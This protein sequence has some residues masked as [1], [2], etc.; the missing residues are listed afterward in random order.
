MSR[1]ISFLGLFFPPPPVRHC[2]G[3]LGERNFLEFKG[4]DSDKSGLMG[5][6]GGELVLEEEFLTSECGWTDWYV[7]SPS[8]TSWVLGAVVD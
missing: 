1:D 3:Y 7:I 2:V 5:R 4:S 6:G 8:F